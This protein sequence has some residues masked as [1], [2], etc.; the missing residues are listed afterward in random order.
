MEPVSILVLVPIVSLA[1]GWVGAYFG[2]Y[3]REKGKNLAT[4]EDLDRI[5][6]VTEEIRTQMSGDLWVRQRRWEV[7][8][9]TYRTLLRQIS[10]I[11][12]ILLQHRAI[13]QAQARLAREGKPADNEL[14]AMNRQFNER[15]DSAFEE[16]RNAGAIAPLV[17][18]AESE[19]ALAQLVA[20]WSQAQKEER[21]Y[22]AFA[23]RLRTRLK[24][25]FSD[26]LGA[27]RRDLVLVDQSGDQA[28]VIA[29]IHARK[30]TDQ[31]LPDE[32][33]R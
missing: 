4:R 10:E 28:S 11:G 8:L 9:E 24:A 21:G 19:R 27:A 3:F 25:A 17:V 1:G 13:D 23:E 22:A 30:S 18:S 5:T 6:R 26:V 16:L 32:E 7:K 31:N 14:E 33:D 20:D 29:A 2:A 15:I 12:F